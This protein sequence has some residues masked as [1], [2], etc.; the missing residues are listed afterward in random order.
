MLL[1][2]FPV[3]EFPWQSIEMFCPLP[4]STPF[5]VVLAESRLL[6]ALLSEFPKKTIPVAAFAV[7]MLVNALLLL[8]Y[9]LYALYPVLEETRL[10][11]LFLSQNLVT[12][13]DLT[14]AVS[15]RK[16]L[17]AETF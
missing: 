9:I 2:L 11:K 5:P 3:M 1:A 4:T 6:I 12:T 8:L 15:L 14:C 17:H 16:T 13:L 10:V 7:V